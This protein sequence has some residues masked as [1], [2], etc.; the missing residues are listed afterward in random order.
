MY[1]VGVERYIFK[2]AVPLKNRDF[3]DGFL[4]CREISFLM[5]AWAYEY[6]ELSGSALAWMNNAALSKNSVLA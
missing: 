1:R 5:G 3:W 6:E 4:S 2:R